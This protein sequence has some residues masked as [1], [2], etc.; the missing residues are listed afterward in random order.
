MLSNTPG[1]TVEI[2]RRED[3]PDEQMGSQHCARKHD[4]DEAACSESGD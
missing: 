3:G 1:H 2:F 4:E